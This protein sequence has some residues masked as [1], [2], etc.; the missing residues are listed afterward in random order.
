M[1]VFVCAMGKEQRQFH[2]NPCITDMMRRPVSSEY[3]RKPDLDFIWVVL[4]CSGM[5]AFSLSCS[6]SHAA[7]HG[8]QGPSRKDTLQRTGQGAAGHSGQAAAREGAARSLL[9]D[10]AWVSLC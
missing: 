10:T 7:A 4:F 6:S 8:M 9:G 5:A 1:P 3:G 2:Q